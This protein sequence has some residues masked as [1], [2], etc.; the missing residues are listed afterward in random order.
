MSAHAEGGQLGRWPCN[1]AAYSQSAS[2]SLSLSLSLTFL[3]FSHW[4]PCGPFSGSRFQCKSSSSFPQA[5]VSLT[6]S[7]SNCPLSALKG[8]SF[9][10]GVHWLLAVCGTCPGHVTKGFGH[11]RTSALAWQ[12][13]GE[14]QCKRINNNTHRHS[15]TPSAM[16]QDRSTMTVLFL[17]WIGYPRHESC[18]EQQSSAQDKIFK[19]ICFVWVHHI[20]YLLECTGH[21]RF[22]WF[23]CWLSFSSWIIENMSFQKISCCDWISS[24]PHLHLCQ[25]KCTVASPSLQ[26]PWTLSDSLHSNDRANQIIRSENDRQHLWDLSCG[27]KKSI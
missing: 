17:H 14:S 23:Y 22:I 18:T 6:G 7:F 1:S 4:F 21:D 12:R 10:V 2:L 19:L 8:W 27:H 15:H 25:I 9:S 16:Q 26:I 5:S 3:S 20:L 13:R 11:V 24:K